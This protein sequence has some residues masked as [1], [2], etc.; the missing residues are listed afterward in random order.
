MKIKFISLSILIFFIQPVNAGFFD[1]LNFK[2]KGEDISINSECVT[3]LSKYHDRYTARKMCADKYGS[4]IK[5]DKKKQYKVRGLRNGDM[6]FDINSGIDN[7]VIVS[8]EYSGYA[9][10]PKK[11]KTCKK[12]TFNERQHV[13]ST[14]INNALQVNTYNNWSI[15]KNIK[16]GDWAFTIKNLY[17]YGFTVEY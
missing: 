12:I 1:E 5:L 16:K 15:P 9:H 8:I 3:K 17:I 6:T 13:S 11:N 4:K 2:L 7:M 10:C 14:L